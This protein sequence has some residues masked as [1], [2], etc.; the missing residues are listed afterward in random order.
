[1]AAVEQ[2]RL[3]WIGLGWVGLGWVG[4]GWVG[5]IRYLVVGIREGR[6]S[7]YEHLTQEYCSQR[8]YR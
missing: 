2:M 3:G 8:M 6:G 5:F 7:H 4:L 1:M